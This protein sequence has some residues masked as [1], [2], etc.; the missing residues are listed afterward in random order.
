MHIRQVRPGDET[1][2]A[3]LL[4]DLGRHYGHEPR[5]G[6]VAEGAT[7]L[8]KGGTLCLVADNGGALVGLAILS[9]YVAADSPASAAT[10]T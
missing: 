1:N 8:A 7:F 4:E 3:F 10:A 6:P 2:L 5:P 9:P